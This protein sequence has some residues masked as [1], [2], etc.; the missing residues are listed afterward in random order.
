MR[1][2]TTGTAYVAATLNNV[3]YVPD[4]AKQPGGPIRLFSA[5][6]AADQSGA[7]VTTGSNTRITLRNGLVIPGRRQGKHFFI[8]AIPGFLPDS[9]A[10]V[11][12]LT[13]AS[14]TPAQQQALWH[15]RMCHMNH[16]AVDKVL[17][18][19]SMAPKGVIQP[20]DL[21]CE[22]CALIKRK[23]ANIS[24]NPQERPTTPFSF[25]GLDFW[26]TRD[27]SLQGNRYVFGAVCY[28]TSVVYT[29]FLPSRKPGP[30][31]LK[32]LSSL[33]QSYG[34]ALNR[35]RLDN[36]TVF[37]SHQFHELVTTLSLRLEF[38]APHS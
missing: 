13:L 3:L 15:A 29:V 16:V 25:V 17:R 26:E 5:S 8:D 1:L 38:S 4:L 14:A 11:A 30:A 37:H 12:L 31:C 2:Q 36:D 10:P 28:A 22:T 9:D 18:A 23:V 24:R 21:F 20:T 33:A 35:I 19:H 34:F 32:Q 6:S 7:E 27:E